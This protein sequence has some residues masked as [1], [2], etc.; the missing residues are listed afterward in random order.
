MELSSPMINT[1]RIKVTM[2][3]DFSQFNE[4]YSAKC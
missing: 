2:V 3:T 1:D 4:L